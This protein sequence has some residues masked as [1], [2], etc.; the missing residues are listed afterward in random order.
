MP[1][2][3]NVVFLSDALICPD[4][5][6]GLRAS[7]T[8][9]T[10]PACARIFPVEGQLVSLLPSAA[11]WEPPITAEIEAERARRDLEAPRYDQLLGLRL[12]SHWELPATL[13][14]LRVGPEDRVVDIGCGTGRFTLPLAARCR[15]LIAVDHSLE[16]LRIL[17]RK[18]PASLRSS[19]LLV[20]ADATRLPIRTGWATRATSCQMLEHL[21][22]DGPR[23]AAVSEMARVLAA[24]G[25]LAL[26]AYWHT[27]GLRWLLQKEGKHSGAI[28]FHRFTRDELRALLEREFQ[29][30]SLTGRLV[31]VLLAHLR[32]R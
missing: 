8:G 12:L 25:R 28:Y 19:V 5:G 9:L 10:C 23:R 4:D 15:E 1:P 30:E 21:P 32:R 31:Y 18:L 29:V 2:A 11:A 7:Q 17:G 6:A 27:P 13:E 24:D 22:G 14:P 16:S 26:S 20:Q 3:S